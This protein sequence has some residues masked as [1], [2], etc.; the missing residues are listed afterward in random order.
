[1]QIFTVRRRYQPSDK[2]CFLSDIWLVEW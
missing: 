1:M 2:D